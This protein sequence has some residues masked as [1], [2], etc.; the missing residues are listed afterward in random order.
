MHGL[1]LRRARLDADPETTGRF[2][3]EKRT[4]RVVIEVSVEEAYLHCAK[5]LMRSK[6]WAEESRRERS[7]LPTLGEMI[8]EQIGASGPAETQEEMLARYRPDL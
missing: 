4:P 5:A 1:D 7:A 6:L 8:K 3:T 2:A